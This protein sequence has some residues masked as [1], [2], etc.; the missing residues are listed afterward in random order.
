M[1]TNALNYK[2]YQLNEKSG[3]FSFDFYIPKMSYIILIL[4]IIFFVA[5]Y[6]VEVNK[7]SYFGYQI[8]DYKKQLGELQEKNRRMEIATA[9]KQSLSDLREISGSL[10]MVDGGKFN[11]IVVKDDSFGFAGSLKKVQ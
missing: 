1:N 4:A 5:F 10:D 7:I 8:R 11:Y 6:I 2:N 3:I 9:S